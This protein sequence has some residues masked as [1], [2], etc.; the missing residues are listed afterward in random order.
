MNKNLLGLCILGAVSIL[1]ADDAG[2]RIDERGGERIK[3]TVPQSERRI[4]RTSDKAA[5]SRENRRES[6]REGRRENWRG[7]HRGWESWHRGAWREAW[8]PEYTFYFDATPPYGE[9]CEEIYLDPG[10]GAQINIG[11]G[12]PPSLEFRTRYIRAVKCG[13]SIYVVE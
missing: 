5:P 4:M 12:I 13:N 6:F 2:T 7:S 9:D 1:G 10:T 8:G 3:G 11:I